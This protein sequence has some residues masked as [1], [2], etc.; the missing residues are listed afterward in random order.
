MSVR[1][2]LEALTPLW[3]KRSMSFFSTVKVKSKLLLAV[4][5]IIAAFF[6]FDISIFSFVVWIWYNLPVEESGLM[7]PHCLNDAFQSVS[8]TLN[9]SYNQMTLKMIK[10]YVLN[11]DINF[12]KALEFCQSHNATLWDVQS[13]EEW[14]KVSQFIS[15]FTAMDIWLNGMVEGTDCPSGR[16]CLKNQTHLGLGLPV[17][18][19]PNQRVGTYSR[20]F[21]GNTTE[22]HCLR[23]DPNENNDWITG[24][25]DLEKHTPVCVKRDCFTG[26]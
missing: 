17:R 11:E 18:W 10:I 8:Y 2:R 9:N 14:E 25:C 21:R 24:Y 1:E 5:V 3:L 20:L 26:L 16:D 22:K 13:K 15:S 19:F 12:P 23:V 6:I 7:K 4:Y